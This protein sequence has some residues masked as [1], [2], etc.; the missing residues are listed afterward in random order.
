[1]L[2]LIEDR[3]AVLRVAAAE[4]GV[5]APV[6]GC[7]DWTV[8]DLVAHLGEVHLFWTAVVAAWLRR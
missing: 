2:A 1:M 6:P 5:D 8:A 7:P 4:A 3:S